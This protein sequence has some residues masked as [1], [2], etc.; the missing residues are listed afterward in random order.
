M[1][2][3]FVDAGFRPIFAV[4][5]DQH[6]AATYAA[7]F[8]P[9]TTHTVCADI[10]AVASA[11]VPK[12]DVVIGGPP[13][14]GFSGLGLQDADDPRNKL[15]TE[16]VRIVLASEPEYFVIE[17][18]DRFHKSGEFSRLKHE[19]SEGDL[20]D[21]EITTAVLNSADF[22]VPQRRRRTIVIGRRGRAPSLPN[23]SHSRELSFATEEWRTVRDAIGGVDREARP[24]GSLHDKTVD[25]FGIDV[26]G[27]FEMGDLHFGRNPTE[28][29]LKRYALIPPGGGRFD[30][31][32]AAPELLPNCWKKK[33]TGTTDV[34][35]RLR[36][37]EPALTIRTEFFKPEKGRYLHPDQDR[38]LTHLEAALLQSF[39]AHYLWCGS[40][41]SLARQIGNAVPPLLAHA[42]ARHILSS[43]LA[44]G[45]GSERLQA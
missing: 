7:N 3:G 5:W 22:G 21:Y 23:P 11:D 30:L 28:L 33:S 44:A 1:T 29:S 26:P 15:W 6:A 4:E 36:W 34:M 45:D 40:K 10:A 24:A 8:D 16:Y 2:Q 31:A 37:D 9:D 43:G 20:T 17:N 18:V 25:R 13:C 39:P 19:V 35:G 12:A 41:A 42:I 27:E 32:K 38:P 14:Q